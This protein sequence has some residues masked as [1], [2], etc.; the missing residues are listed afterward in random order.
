MG[1]SNEEQP[2][3][4]FGVWIAK[5][6]KNAVS[7]V[8]PSVAGRKQ[9]QALESVWATETY[10]PPRPI[11]WWVVLGTV[12]FVASLLQEWSTYRKLKSLPVDEQAAAEAAKAAASAA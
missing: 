10:A 5:T 12:Y 3:R 4:R 6:I 9:R 1:S 7:S 8:V 11:R 2:M